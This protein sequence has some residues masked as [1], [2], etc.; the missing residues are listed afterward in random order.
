MANMNIAK[1][2]FY[3][4]LISY[5]IARGTAQNGNFDI[6]AGTNLLS[7]FQTGTEADL[8]D[9][10]P[11]NKVSFDTSSNRTSRVKFNINTQG[12][13]KKSFVAILNHN[14]NSCQ[15]GFF[16]ASA[17]EIDELETADFWSGATHIQTTEVVNA[18]TVNADPYRVDPSTDGSTIVTFSETNHQ[19]IGIQFQGK[20]SGNFSSAN[21][22]SIGAILV[23]EYYDMP[24]APDMSVKRSIIYDNNKIQQSLGGQRYGYSTSFGKTYTQSPFSTASNSRDVYGGRIAYDMN[25]SYLQNTDAMPNEYDDFEFNDDSFT[26]DVWNITDGN[27]RPFIFSVDN[28]SA[29]DNAESEHIFARFDQDTLEMNQSAHNVFNMGIS[30]SEEF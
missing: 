19:Y 30:L 17:D 1:P 23:G 11:L 7:T 16:I 26:G 29:G 3:P 2:R 21:D 20:F 12:S 18:D 14:L 5:L 24:H 4:D 8:F 10:R 13:F 15:G 9:L 25:F 27:H 22:L 28:S 6:E